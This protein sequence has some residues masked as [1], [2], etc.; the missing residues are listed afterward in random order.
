MR[1]VPFFFD[2]FP[3]SRRPDYPRYRGERRTRVVI[4]GG[5]LTGCACA[6]SFAAAGVDVIMLESDRIGAGTTAASPGLLRQDLDASFSASA[7]Q[8]GL[9]VAR[10]VW[11]SFRRASLDF[12]AALR[13]F[14]IRADLTPQ[15][16]L[17]FTR[18]GADA[19]RR[20]RREQQARRAAGVEAVWL[21]PRALAAETAISANGAIRT[22][23][24]A[25]DPYRACVGL[26]AAAA[27]R[28]ASIHE[29]TVVRR[30]R[31]TR[32]FVE[33][34]AEGGVIRAESVVLATGGLIDDLKALRRHFRPVQS[35]LVV[36]ES[37]PA[38]V[39]REVGKRAAALR[40]TADPPHVLR[41]LKDDRVLFGGADQPPVPSRARDRARV[42]QANE[43][44]YKLT[45]L[46]PAIS[47]LQPEWAWDATTHASPD[48]LPVVGPHR[49]FP[50]HLFA[51]G[52]GRHGAA[53]A[54]LA[55]RVLLRAFLGEPARG[56]EFFGF[57][58]IL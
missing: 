11:Q 38:A 34:R 25:L 23:G 40:D 49:N 2:T 46:Y 54:W 55:A 7:E 26:A 22:R 51:L 20:L 3:R 33:V 41:W 6:A 1:P 17:Y 19:A 9:R 57:G 16:L 52:H 15:D 36:T 56:D 24:D 58:R 39:R 29:R 13:R 28:G 4:V 21:T 42:Q 27:S 31:A 8:H 18:D 32:K 10:H 44:M 14:G 50:R 48:G 53:M 43:L 12:A 35:Y 30:V 37:M 45:T 47:G 5:G